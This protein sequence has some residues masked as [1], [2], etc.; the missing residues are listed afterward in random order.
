MGRGPQ[1]S[2][3]GAGLAGPRE[4]PGLLRGSDLAGAGRAASCPVQSTPLLQGPPP[5]TR[6]PPRH[7]EGLV[8]VPGLVRITFGKGS[9]TVSWSSLISCKGKTVIQVSRLSG[10]KG[11]LRAGSGGQAGSAAPARPQPPAPWRVPRPS[12]R[13]SRAPPQPGA[14]MRSACCPGAGTVSGPTVPQDGAGMHQDSRG[15]ERICSPGQE[16]TPPGLG[17][18]RIYSL[19]WRRGPTKR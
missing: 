16:T 17:W 4:E 9:Q 13:P 12:Q 7:L 1:L 10:D 2:A 11:A 15:K 5:P 18:L 19:A 3:K 8:R 14:G 6:H